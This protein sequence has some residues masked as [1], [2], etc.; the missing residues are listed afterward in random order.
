ML[1]LNSKVNFMSKAIPQDII[2]KLCFLSHNNGINGKTNLSNYV[3]NAC[4]EKGDEIGWQGL[5]VMF[6]VHDPVL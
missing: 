6:G 3:C 4:I 2:Q 1:N 5:F